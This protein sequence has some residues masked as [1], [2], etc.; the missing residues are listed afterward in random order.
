MNGDARPRA[1][2]QRSRW[3]CLIKDFY[4]LLRGLNQPEASLSLSLPL[5]ELGFHKVAGTEEVRESLSGKN[6]STLIADS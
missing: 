5:M 1:T 3:P 4:H 2:N 6:R